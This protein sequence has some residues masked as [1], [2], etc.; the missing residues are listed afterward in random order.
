MREFIKKRITSCK[1][2]V[3][4]VVVVAGCLLLVAGVNSCR[5]DRAAVSD[6]RSDNIEYSDQLGATAAVHSERI[7]EISERHTE[8]LREVSERYHATAGERKTIIEEI[9]ALE[10]YRDS[11]DEY[12]R[13]LD[14]GG[15]Y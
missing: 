15:N 3:L 1:P 10:V 8:T 2:L 12:M 13:E 7:A 5:E 9:E 14:S 11:V 6:V 4:F